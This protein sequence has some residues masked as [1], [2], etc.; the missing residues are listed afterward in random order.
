MFPWQRVSIVILSF[1]SGFSRPENCCF[2][3]TGSRQRKL[4]W[5]G[6]TTRRRE[7]E[8]SEKQQRTSEQ[9]EKRRTPTWTKPRE[10]TRRRREHSAEQRTKWPEQRTTTTRTRRGS[11]WRT[12]NWRGGPAS[13]C[14]KRA[15]RDWYSCPPEPGTRRTPRQRASEGETTK[16]QSTIDRKSSI[17]RWTSRGSERERRIGVEGM[18]NTATH[19][20]RTMKGRK[21]ENRRRKRR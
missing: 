14:R 3:S 19:W 11:L 21:R 1:S 13:R 15:R 5:G 17:R 9:R 6:K 10:G 16:K 12:T 7:R 18:K 4:R 8:Q 20:K 2:D